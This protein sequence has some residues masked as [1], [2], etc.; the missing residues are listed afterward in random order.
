MK[1]FWAILLCVFFAGMSLTFQ[2]CTTVASPF[3]SAILG[4]A[5]LA[6]K[7]AELQKEIR[8]ADVQEALDSPFEKTWN[9]AV[10]ALMNL[11]VEITRIQKNQE[12]DG[13]VIEGRA[14]K[15]E[16]KIIAVKLTE[17]ITEIG[18]WAEHDKAL[19]KL[20]AEKIREEGQKENN[21]VPAES[22]SYD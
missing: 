15:I 21:Q 14:Q 8:K 17:E 1:K 16:I 3:L 2:A 11:H 18:V 20:I 9:V 13:G 19:A 5:Q 4:G 12:E 22:C 7:G 10:M 6:I